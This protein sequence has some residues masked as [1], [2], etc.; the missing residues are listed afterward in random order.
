MPY[1]AH[2]QFQWGWGILTSCG[3]FSPLRF[4]SRCVKEAE[5]QKTEATIS[6][7][8]WE[9]PFAYIVHRLSGDHPRDHRLP[10]ADPHGHFGGHALADCERSPS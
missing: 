1:M 4:K 8:A 2:L 9:G 5:L 10:E 7:E 6:F 3:V